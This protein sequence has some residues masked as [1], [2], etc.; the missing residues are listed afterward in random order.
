MPTNETPLS[1]AGVLLRSL[2]AIL[3]A[4]LT[5]PTLFLMLPVLVL[6]ALAILISTLTLRTCFRQNSPLVHRVVA[7]VPIP[8]AIWMFLT[9]WH[10][11]ST[12]YRA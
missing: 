7:A 3:L 9:C 4:L 6:P 1:L 8:V 10:I 5:M 12:G 11:I 2:L